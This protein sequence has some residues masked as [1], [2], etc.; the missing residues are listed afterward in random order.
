MA[1]TLFKL[2]ISAQ[3]TTTVL[4]KPDVQ[5]LFYNFDP[6]DVDEGVLTIA[7]GSFVDDTGSTVSTMPLITTDNG[8]YMLFINGVLQQETL[9]TVSETGVEIPDI[10]DVP[11]G[12]PI[13]LVVTNFTPTADSQTTFLT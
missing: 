8:Y 2:V 1:A 10:G 7:P 13:I 9:Y 12:A 11:E 4:T 6:E 5:R 3:T